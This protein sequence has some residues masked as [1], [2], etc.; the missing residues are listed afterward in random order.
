M[1]PFWSSIAACPGPLSPATEQPW[2]WEKGGL[3][4]EQRP[5][6]AQLW[7]TQVLPGSALVVIWS[8]HRVWLFVTLRTVACQAPPSM[9]F[10]RQECWSGCR[11]LLQASSRPRDRTCIACTASKPSTTEP[12]G[13][14]CHHY[15]SILV[16]ISIFS[17]ISHQI[18]Q[19]TRITFEVKAKMLR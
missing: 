5:P 1:E 19:W 17:S 16:K 3:D 10:S 6:E 13:R 14:P 8:P 4:G 18:L 15:F 12:P 11:C 7:Q 2:G 9:G